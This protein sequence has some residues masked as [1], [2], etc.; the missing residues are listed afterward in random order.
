MWLFGPF[1]SFCIVRV[2]LMQRRQLWRIICH[3]FYLCPLQSL[4]VGI[5]HTEALLKAFTRYASSTCLCICVK[6]SLFIRC[7]E[8]FLRKKKRLSDLYFL[9]YCDYFRW[10]FC[11]PIWILMCL[12]QSQCKFILPIMFFG[13]CGSVNVFLAS[14]VQFHISSSDFVA[15][16]VTCTFFSSIILWTTCTVI[17]LFASFQ[18]LYRTSTFLRPFGYN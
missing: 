17:A 16:C 14:T 18:S 15:F 11:R 4:L 12:L 10:A 3:C 2:F 6:C 5:L 1:E 8:V 13:S 9:R 7:S